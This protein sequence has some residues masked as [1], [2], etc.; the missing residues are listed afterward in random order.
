LNSERDMAA[1]GEVGGNS[2]GRSI[3]EPTVDLPGG[4]PTPFPG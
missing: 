2:V 3:G 4:L 1:D